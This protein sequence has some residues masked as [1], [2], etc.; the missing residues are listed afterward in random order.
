MDVTRDQ[1]RVRKWRVLQGTENLMSKSNYRV[2]QPA[3][4]PPVSCLS[5]LDAF[6][7]AELS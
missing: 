3:T 4:P 2:G 6:N 7:Q 1:K 5:A